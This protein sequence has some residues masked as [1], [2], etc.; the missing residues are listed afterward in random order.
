MAISK[1]FTYQEWLRTQETLLS[2]YT[3]LD[4][5]GIYP[6][7]ATHVRNDDAQVTKKGR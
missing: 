5:H 1:V 7:M 4:T 3:A 2:A 6:W